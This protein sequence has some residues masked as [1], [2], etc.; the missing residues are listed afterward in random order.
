LQRLF[1][2]LCTKAGGAEKSFSLT[3]TVGRR[4]SRLCL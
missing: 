4:F 3:F 2:S 1:G